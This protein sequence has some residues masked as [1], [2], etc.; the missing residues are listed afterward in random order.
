M[1][2]NKKNHF[3]E[4]SQHIMVRSVYNRNTPYFNSNN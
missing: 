3:T 4:K 1:E 2:N